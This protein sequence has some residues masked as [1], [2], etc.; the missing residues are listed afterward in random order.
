[1]ETDIKAYLEYLREQQQRENEKEWTRRADM[2]YRTMAMS[3]VAEKRVEKI[4]SLWK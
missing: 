2:I 1:M 4:K 3:M